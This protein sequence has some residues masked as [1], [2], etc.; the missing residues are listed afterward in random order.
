M[1]IHTLALQSTT[2]AKIRKT[3][4]IDHMDYRRIQLLEKANTLVGYTTYASAAGSNQIANLG[5]KPKQLCCSSFVAWTYYHA[6]I[7]TDL[8][9]NGKAAIDV[10]CDS[11]PKT[12]YFESVS[13]SKLLP[14]DIAWAPGQHIGIYVGTTK[15][16]VKMYIHCSGN[17]GRNGVVIDHDSRFTKFYRYK[18]FK[19]DGTNSSG[20]AYGAKSK[21]KKKNSNNSSQTDMDQWMEGYDS[22]VGC[23]G[24]NSILGDPN[25][26]N[27][28]AWLLQQILN[29]IKVLGPLLVIIL[30]GMDFAKVI[31]RSD[32]ESMAK[33]QKKLIIRLLLAASLF[34]IPNL[35]SVLLN[36]FGITSDPTCG[37]S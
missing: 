14:G 18:N 22:E 37:I 7:I 19:D 13:A 16:G 30:S 36:I 20:D 10:N 32:D 27:S 29:Y 21:K 24:K 12:K 5:S 15:S 26:E 28:V 33:A 8:K 9:S 6:G 1:P 17:S 34:F 31:I 25:D 3:W 4:D 2:L 35:V 23:S 11:I